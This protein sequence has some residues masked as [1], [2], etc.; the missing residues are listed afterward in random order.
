MN[1][2][3]N[4]SWT[5]HLS[6]FKPLMKIDKKK[7]P[8]IKFYELLSFKGFSLFLKTAKQLLWFWRRR[9]FSNKIE[10]IVR[11]SVW[12]CE[13]VWVCVS[14]CEWV[15]VCVCVKTL[16]MSG[17]YAKMYCM[18]HWHKHTHTHT[19]T[20]IHTHTHTHTWHCVNSQ[21]LLR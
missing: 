4:Y 15:C 11:V 13:C 21:H 3:N 17:L 18:Y 7:I 10:K 12:V 1:C 16:S 5:Y 19:Q 8:D 6:P 20:H 9:R 14:V 2:R